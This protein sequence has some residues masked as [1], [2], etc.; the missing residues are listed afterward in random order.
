MRSQLRL[1]T[2]LTSARRCRRRHRRVRVVGA[3]IRRISAEQGRL[4]LVAGVPPALPQLR[5]RAAV[6]REHHHRRVVPRRPHHLCMGAHQRAA[7]AA[8]LERRR[9]A[10]LDRGRVRSHQVHRPD[11][12]GHHRRGGARRV[13]CTRARELTMPRGRD[14]LARPRPNSRATILMA[15]PKA[16]TSI[17]T[18]TSTPLTSPSPMVRD[19]R[20]CVAYRSDAWRR[21]VQSGPTSGSAT[22]AATSA[23]CS[24]SSSSGMSAT[25]RQARS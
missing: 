22:A 13:A 21:G 15:A 3:L 18:T 23:A 17:A 12:L 7:R 5:H 10:E 4:L 20:L 25:L 2:E 19:A 8:G 1:P 6:T 9:A 24:P 16:Q 11:A 14:S